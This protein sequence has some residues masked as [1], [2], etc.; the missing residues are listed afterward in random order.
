MAG[1]YY[2]VVK[3]ETFH[4]LIVGKQTSLLETR[5]GRSSAVGGG[6]VSV[7]NPVEVHLMAERRDLL[8][9]HKRA[10]DLECF[11]DRKGNHRIE[12]GIPSQAEFG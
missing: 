5:L 4:L 7:R 8:E 6:C 10:V 11:G 9:A 2:F 3:T 1:K 12:T